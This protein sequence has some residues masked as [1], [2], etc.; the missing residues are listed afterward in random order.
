MNHGDKRAL[1]DRIVNELRGRF[2]INDPIDGLMAQPNKVVEV[3][4]AAINDF[5]G[6]A[7]G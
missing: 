1:A 4:F 3:V 7:N 5:T 6:E 2:R